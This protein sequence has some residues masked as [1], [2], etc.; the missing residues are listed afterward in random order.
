MSTLPDNV[1]VHV[2]EYQYAFDVYQ[3]LIDLF[4]NITIRSMRQKFDTLWF[5]RYNGQ[6]P[7]QYVAT[8]RKAAK[9]LADCDP[10]NA[11]SQKLL[12]H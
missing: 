7:T 1:S 4:G 10:D 11:L 8:F 9:E 3:R 12:F 5:L 2:E 6:N